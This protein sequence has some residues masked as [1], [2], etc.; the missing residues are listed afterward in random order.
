MDTSP[1]RTPQVLPRQTP[2]TTRPQVMPRQ[3]PG[4]HL[5]VD[6]STRHP[7]THQHQV[8]PYRAPSTHGPTQGEAITPDETAT[9]QPQRSR[10][11]HERHA[12]GEAN[13]NE[14]ERTSETARTN[15]AT[16]ERTLH[17]NEQTAN[18]SVPAHGSRGER[19]ATSTPATRALS[20]GH[21]VGT[22]SRPLAGA[23][24]A[25]S[26]GRPWLRTAYPPNAQR[27]GA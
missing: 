22:A 19:P 26:G 23:P 2:G 5:P 12:S 1:T 17:T 21:P 9:R 15:S 27:S 16:N 4:A 14:R 6:L 20:A 3:T 10:F 13:V 18:G 25:P 11:G 24:S 7:D 8:T